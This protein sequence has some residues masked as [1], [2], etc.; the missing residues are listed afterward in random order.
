MV[1]DKTG[2][3]TLGR[4]DVTDVVSIGE[5]ETTVLTLAASLEPRSEHTLAAGIARAASTSRPRPG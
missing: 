5:S 1:M 4:P 2:T 3:L